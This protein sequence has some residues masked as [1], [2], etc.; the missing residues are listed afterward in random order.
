MRA[1]RDVSTGDGR[2]VLRG[3]R[4]I[5]VAAL[6]AAGAMGAAAAWAQEPLPAG[7]Y[8]GGTIVDPP[9]SPYGAGNMVISLRTSG[10]GK[11][12]V[13][14]LMGARCS[15]ATI[16]AIATV[17]ADGTFA[18]SG[19]ATERYPG[20]RLR[21]T[22]T[23]TGVIDGLGASGSASGSS[24]DKLRG[25]RARKCKTGVVQWGARRASGAIGTPAATLPIARYYGN[26]SQGVGKRRHGI[27]L[28][29]SADGTRVTR[30]LYSVN[31]RCLGRTFAALDAP[32]NRNLPIN[33]GGK[34]SDVERYTLRLSRRVRLRFV[35]RLSG[36]I[37]STGA[38]GRL[39]ISGRYI[40]RR[41]RTLGRCRSGSVK[42]SAGI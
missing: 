11:V 36:T 31:I 5:A 20:G 19:T 24:T 39:S 27:V 9:A 33:A 4:L 21:T 16:K 34:F 15:T 2:F 25:R 32:G 6:C 29:I 42:W 10:A 37:G 26:T 28:R 22:Y 14:A 30:T 17:A 23:I 3:W 38:Q 18:A 35:E 12:Q 13:L 41:G 8:G 7:N 40:D 1:A